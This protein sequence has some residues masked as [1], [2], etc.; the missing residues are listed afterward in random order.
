MGLTTVQSIE[1]KHSE[2][3]PSFEEYVTNICHGNHIQITKTQR[4]FLKRAYDINV[5]GHMPWSL[6]DF[7]DMFK[8]DYFRKIKERLSPFIELVIGG[9]PHFYKLKGIHYTYFV[10]KTPTRVYTKDVEP[11]FER[12]LSQV[13]KQPLMM[14]D[15]RIEARVAQLYENILLNT[16][17]EFNDHNFAFTISI[18]AGRQFTVTVNVYRNNKMQIMIGC[19]RLPLRYDIGGF[20]ELSALMGSVCQYLKDITGVEFY[21]N[22]IP[23]WIIQYLHLNQDGVE[24]SGERFRYT[25]AD[26]SNHSVFYLKKFNDGKIKPRYEEHQQPN[27]TIEEMM[28]S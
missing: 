19:T 28:K 7:K 22:P 10:T 3:N 13:K 4:K 27:K 9:N 18:P 23:D 15:I 5:I 1:D 21:H 11:E 24:I 2:I 17:L 14:H 6:V 26:L 12:I 16:D 25:I 20:H 8:P